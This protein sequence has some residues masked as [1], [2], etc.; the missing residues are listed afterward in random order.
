ME[1]IGKWAMFQ[2]KGPNTAWQLIGLCIIM[3]QGKQ[4]FQ[5]MQHSS[6]EKRHLAASMLREAE[7]IPCPLV[8]D[9]MNNNASYSYGA[10]PGEE[11]IKHAL[12]ACN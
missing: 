8:L 10:Y 9:A 4:S 1:A 6:L 2:T 3:S 12:D 7:D 11:I 5:L